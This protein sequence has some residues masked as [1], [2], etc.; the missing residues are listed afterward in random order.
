MH[1]GRRLTPGLRRLPVLASVLSTASTYLI[2]P[3]ADVHGKAE[4]RPRFSAHVSAALRRSLAFVRVRV[5]KRPQT[6]IE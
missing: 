2:V 5:E 4:R 6:W 3:S 1:A